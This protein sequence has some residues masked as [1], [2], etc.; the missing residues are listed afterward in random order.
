METADAAAEKHI[1]QTAGAYRLQSSLP[2]GKFP[3]QE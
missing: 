3:V 1:L 2:R